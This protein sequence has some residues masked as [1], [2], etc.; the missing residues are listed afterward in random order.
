[1]TSITYKDQAYKERVGQ[2]W[3]WWWWKK[4]RRP[5]IGVVCTYSVAVPGEGELLVRVDEDLLFTS[6]VLVGL[7]HH[8]PDGKIVQVHLICRRERMKRVQR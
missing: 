1:L 6:L 8:S 4:R 7:A 5:I 2:R 3:W